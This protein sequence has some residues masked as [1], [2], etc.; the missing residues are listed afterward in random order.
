MD[1]LL[2]KKI[3]EGLKK[4]ELSSFE[5]FV[6]YYQRDIY[7]I[8]LRFLNNEQD[9]LDVTQEIFLKVLKK[10]DSFQGNS[11]LSTWLY[12]ITINYCKDYVKKYYKHTNLYIDKG[13]DGE[14]GEIYYQLPSDEGEPSMV[15]EEKLKK[16]ALYKCIEL[17]EPEFKEVIILKYINQL[18][19]GEM[20]EILNIPEGT[21]K[22][23]LHRGR[24][25][26][27]KLLKERE[28]L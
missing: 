24:L 4:G 18:S 15:L 10:I 2:E 19:Y 25:N 20:G 26:L 14:E 16:E 3:V 12:R 22:S 27:A 13:I 8:A 5:E 1:P 11:K 9:A 23:R 6:K 7:N 28:L 21:V 17:L